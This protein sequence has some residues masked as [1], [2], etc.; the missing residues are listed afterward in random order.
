MISEKQLA[1]YFHSFWDDHFPLLN[2]SFIRRFNLEK[3]QRLHTESGKMVSAIEMGRGSDRF[4]LIAELAFELAMTSYQDD[5]GANRGPSSAIVR[6]MARIATLKGLSTIPEASVGEL[7]EAHALL[8]N[9]LVFFKTVA[10][11]GDLRFRPLIKGVGFLSQ[12]EADFC[13]SRVLFEV[14]AVNRNLQS[15]DLRQVICYLVAGLRSKDYSWTKYCIFNPR[16]ATYYVG[17][18]EGLLEYLSGR[19]SSE[20]IHDVSSAL[21]EREQPI[22]MKF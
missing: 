7:E 4:D 12:M 20:C 19:S 9:Y 11:T 1:E 17:E 10:T 15:T 8:Q 16:L 14:K 13:S 21:M 6:A 5:T 3:K 2:S 22:E 18:V